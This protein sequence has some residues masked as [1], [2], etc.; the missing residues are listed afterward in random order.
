M[1]SLLPTAA[2]TSPSST[3]SPTE[4]STNTLTLTTTVEISQQNMCEVLQQIASRAPGNFVC[5]TNQ[6]CDGVD[7]TV[8][9]LNNGMPFQS[10]AVILVCQLPCPAVEIILLSSSP[11]L[12][13]LWTTQKYCQFNSSC[14]TVKTFGLLQPYF[15]H[16]SCMPVV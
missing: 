2:P 1:F 16:L 5:S 3:P 6:R 4:T 10:R 9:L 7:C 15:G 13:R 11:L 14:N 12:M 8:D